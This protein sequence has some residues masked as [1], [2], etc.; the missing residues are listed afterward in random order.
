M[1]QTVKTVFEIRVEQ[2]HL[3]TRGLQIFVE[4][5]SP[6]RLAGARLPLLQVT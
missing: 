3:S 5:I 1:P 2:P 6:C 4:A